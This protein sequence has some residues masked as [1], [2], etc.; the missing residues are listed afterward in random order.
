MLKRK[1]AVVTGST[2]GIGLGIARALAA[3]GAD[4]L[5]NGFGR[6]EKIENV[7]SSLADTHGL[8]VSYSAANMSKADE[9]DGIIAQAT[10]DLGGV[11]ILVK[12]ATSSIRRRP[13]TER[14]QSPPVGET[15]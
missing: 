10:C 1:A 11:D 8:R 12:N 15:I 6:A 14:V 9:V 2:S 5:L 3:Q 4:V 13:A 7:R